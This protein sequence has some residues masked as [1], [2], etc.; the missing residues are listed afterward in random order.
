[1]QPESRHHVG[2]SVACICLATSHS[3]S[4]QSLSLPS[5]MPTRALMTMKEDEEEREAEEEEGDVEEEEEGGELSDEDAETVIDENVNGR[6]GNRDT[7]VRAWNGQKGNRRADVKARTRSLMQGYLPL[8][9]R[10]W[11]KSANFTIPHGYCDKTYWGL[12]FRNTV[13]GDVDAAI[14]RRPPTLV[15]ECPRDTRICFARQLDNYVQLKKVLVDGRGRVFR[16][17]DK[18]IRR[19]LAVIDGMPKNMAVSEY[20]LSVKEMFRVRG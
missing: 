19:A 6:K 9:K 17:P 10:R 11:Q 2:M 14:Q 13:R 8:S 12:T 7:G 1:M 20:I 15:T 18:D 5:P 16:A 4:P 3:L